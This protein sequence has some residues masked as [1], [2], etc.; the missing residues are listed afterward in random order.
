MFRRRKKEKSLNYILAFFF[1][2][3]PAKQTNKQTYTFVKV[4]M[5]AFTNGETISQI[6]I[7]MDVKYSSLW[8]N[9][10]GHGSLCE[11]TWYHES[12]SEK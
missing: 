12:Q 1:I 3:W 6:Q 11:Y 8:G 5:S 10:W 4:R 2:L 9:N 7:Q